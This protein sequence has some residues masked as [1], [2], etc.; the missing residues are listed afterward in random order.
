[1]WYRMIKLIIILLY[2][3]QYN[4]HNNIIGIPTL[5]N[6]VATLGLAYT[7]HMYNIYICT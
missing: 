3:I 5:T 2:Y 6:M 1:M 4:K 7:V